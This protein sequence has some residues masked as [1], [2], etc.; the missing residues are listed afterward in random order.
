MKSPVKIPEYG[1]QWPWLF[2]MERHLILRAIGHI[3]VRIEHISSTAVPSLG[4][5]PTI[6]IMVAINHLND[7]DRCI[8][9]LQRIGYEY[10]PEHETSTPQRRF[11]RKG[12]PPKE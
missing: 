2:E 10:Q 11:F 12:E 8:D 1:P 4:A 3:I 9:P 6:D 5:K 7:S